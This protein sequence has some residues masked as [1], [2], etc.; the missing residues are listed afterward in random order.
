VEPG[1]DDP[2]TPGFSLALLAE[3]VTSA[4]AA[5]LAPYRVP[6]Y[7]RAAFPPE[8]ALETA[9]E[10]SRIKTS[11]SALAVTWVCAVTSALAMAALTLAATL[12]SDEASASTD[13]ACRIVLSATPTAAAISAAVLKVATVATL[14]GR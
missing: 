5:Y 1:F 2:G 11:A 10:T 7:Q 4:F 12:T 8:T 3:L 9:L 13:S 14:F 6:A